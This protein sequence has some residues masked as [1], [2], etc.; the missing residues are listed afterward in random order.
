ML[1]ER[2]ATTSGDAQSGSSEWRGTD[3]FEVLSRLGRGGMGVVYEVF[4]RQRGERVALKTLLHFDA[5]GLYRF[6]QEFRTL[7][8]I[9]HPNLV[10]LYELVAAEREEVFFTM[11]LVDGTDFL[12][13]VQGARQ[14]GDPL[15]EAITAR[16]GVKRA[17]A[18]H[19]PPGALE[20]SR[21]S[22]AASPANLDGLRSA[23]R[24]LVEGVRAVHAAGKLHRDLKPANVRVTPEGHLVILDFGVA[25]E[26]RRHG[27]AKDVDDGQYPEVVGTAAYMAPEQ[28][29]GDAPVAASDWYSVGAML[30]EALV[31]RPPFTGSAIDVLTQKLRLRPSEPAF[32]VQGVPADLN[33]LCMALLATDPGQ[34]P[35]ADQIL[36]RLGVTPS[37]PAP[38]ADRVDR[39]EATHLVG[40]EA[41]L[42]ALKAA[43]ESTREGRAVAVRVSGLSGMGKS[44]VV[45]HFLDDLERRID[46]LVLRGR[47]YERE[48]MPY[49]AVD[50]V[51][52]ALTRHLVELYENE[53]TVALPDEIWALAHV[54]PVLRR[55]PSIDAVP[56]ASVGD[57]QLVRLH[58]FGVLR[59]LFAS[60]S[61]SQHVVIFVDDVQWGDT[62]SAALL[63]EL[64]RPPAAPPLL[65]ITTHRAE[66]SDASPF[67][68]DLRARWPADAEVHD[69]TVG[70]LGGD[71]ARRLALHL[72]GSQD[73]SAEHTADAIARES[74]GSPFLIEELTRS[75][76]IDIAGPR[77][78]LTLETLV[79]ERVSRLPDDARRLLETVAVGGRPLPVAT[80]GAASDT[81]E[82]VNQLVALLRARRFVRAGL[83]DGREVV[84]MSHDRIRETV[85]AQIAGPVVRGHHER[86]ART[87]EATPDSDPEAITTH[88]LGAGNKER[89]AH[90]AER[91][92]EQ[93]L[94]KLAFAQ[95]ARLFQLTCD[96]ISPSS[97]DARRLQR[98]VA[99][100]C[101]WAGYAEK[102]ARAYLTAAEGAPSLER[103]D[104]ERAAAA[105][106]I[107]AGRIDESVALSRRVLAAVGRTVP[108][109]ILGTIFWVVFYRVLSKFLTRKELTKAGELP[110]AE[111]VRLDA[112]HTMSRGLAVVDAI[113]A[114]YVKARYLVDALRSGNRYHIVRAA[115]VEASGGAAS[116][117][118]GKRERDLFDLAR[119]LAQETRDDEGYALYQITYG[120]SE[121]VRGRWRPALQMLDEACARLAAARRWQ[122]N[123]NVYGVYA[124]VYLG[125]LREARSRTTRLLA[126]AERRGDLYTAVNLRAS[127]PIA[128]W[129]ATDDIEGARR[130]I[131]ESVGQWSKT[132][133]LVQHWQAMLWEAEIDLYAGDGARAWERLARDGRSL[134]KSHLLSVQLIRAFTH[135]ILGRSA[136]ASLVTLPDGERRARLAQ[137]R[138][139]QR[140]LAAEGIAW[141]TVLAALLEASIANVGGDTLRTERALRDAIE[142]S[143]AAEMSLHGAAARFRLGLLL[144]GQEGSAMTQRAEDEMK[145][146]D[147]RVPGHY[148]RMLVPGSWPASS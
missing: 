111:R 66:E 128:T 122:A 18:S 59:Q 137:A 117:K 31:G 144:G 97:P 75:A 129:L 138:H 12:G 67:L 33:D 20:A 25:T 38:A 52:D 74:G 92:A 110:M 82:S 43:F 24:Q 146:Q 45:Q 21:H 123:A 94:A 133:F 130:H 80:V 28:A 62:D 39:P 27:P 29:S 147:V 10:H 57:P 77:R 118:E 64:M 58:A 19:A 99:E 112:L 136:I 91:A 135:F 106:L 56:Q 84:E 124:L 41:Q 76:A 42:L 6:K 100:A 113:S 85:V 53:R 98:R 87:L 47:A 104:L 37:E 126:D 13:Y 30:Y 101:E 125:E 86:L 11:E 95:A 32:C 68:I 34:R 90:Y 51:V 7:A 114:M 132:R 73:A 79:G 72:L 5:D 69:L 14:G 8:D 134:K 109:S 9:L 70:P 71:D 108:G 88:L 83:R 44:A 119:R 127:H 78:S 16:S 142:R 102:A 107:A 96:T 121:Y 50:S 81:Q 36:R 65:L 105:Q 148:F 60:L 40:R 61:R 49:K 141:T 35:T 55:V 48:S 143:Q 23:L 131:R 115:A 22:K 145:R 1:E 26:L 120:I 140:V 103:V 15:K 4:D 93:A 54:F 17:R 3:R 63:V 46:V 89:A 116:G 139:S 2:A